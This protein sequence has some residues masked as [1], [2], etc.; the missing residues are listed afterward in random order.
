VDGLPGREFALRGEDFRGDVV[1]EVKVQLSDPQE[2]QSL[3]WG[4]TTV[5]EIETP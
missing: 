4:M 5:V 3:H 1:Y 2:A